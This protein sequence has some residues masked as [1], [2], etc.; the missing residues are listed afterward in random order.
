MQKNKNTNKKKVWDVIVIG[1]GP[2]GMMAAGTAASNGAEVLLL[3]KNDSLGKKLLISGGGRCNVL[4]GELNTRTLL[5]NF[6]QADKFL[7]STFTQFTVEQ[8]FDFF[9]IRNMPTIEEDLKRVFPA[10]QQSASVLE[11]LKVYMSKH[12]VTVNTN[13]AIDTI[14]YKRN[15][16]THITTSSGETLIAK[17]YIVAS[18]G[19]SR[20]ET[21][22]TGDGF[23]WLS[24]GGHVTKD[25]VSSLVPI[26]TKEKW[27]KKLSGLALAN[28]GIKLYQNN[29]PVQKKTGKILFTHTGLSGPGILNMSKD[30]SDLL[31]YGTVSISIDMFPKIDQSGLDK[32]VTELFMRESRKKLKNTLS[33][34]VEQKLVEAICSLA[35]VDLDIFCHSITKEERARL[36]ANCKDLRITVT[37]LMGVDKAV[38]TS[39][40]INLKEIDTKTMRSKVV[41][42]LYII[43]DLLD[44]DRP[45]GGYSLQLC[46]TTGFVAGKHAA[47][48]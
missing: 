25:S 21:G 1:G 46:W 12:K 33:E 23:K 22:S 47:L 6:G 5:S 13:T 29:T 15:K 19:L 35:K 14:V 39:G 30:I 48:D 4:N 37:G 7:F 28:I 38:V 8:T 36:V 41:S 2:A 45:S 17:N 27:S 32:K 3:E 34:L 31:D 43:G 18:G 20:P 9:H 10:S 42:N 24:Q 11:V 44:I 40:G 26:T 16:I